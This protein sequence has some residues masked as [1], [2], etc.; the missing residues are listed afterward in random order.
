M[1][2][3]IR[4]VIYK[5][6]PMWDEDDVFQRNILHGLELWHT[7]NSSKQMGQLG[8]QLCRSTLRVTNITSG[9]LSWLLLTDWLRTP[10]E[11]NGMPVYISPFPS[12]H[13]GYKGENPS[14]S[15]LTY[16][17]W[18]LLPSW[19]SKII[20]NKLVCSLGISLHATGFLSH[21][22]LQLLANTFP[23]EHQQT[24]V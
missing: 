12:P 23:K 19:G 1:A 6:H 9:T 22:V 8:M 17:N 5:T 4:P 10:G 16:L 3:I 2:L 21:I 15:T 11:W 7:S 14:F 18:D 20:F 24:P 13:W